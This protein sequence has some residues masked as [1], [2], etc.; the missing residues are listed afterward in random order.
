MQKIHICAKDKV[1]YGL[2]KHC[3]GRHWG[4]DRPLRETKADPFFIYYTF[5][6]PATHQRQ[7]HCFLARK[8]VGHAWLFSFFM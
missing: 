1:A 3:V 4:K 7:V 6:L 5:A 8:E 2:F